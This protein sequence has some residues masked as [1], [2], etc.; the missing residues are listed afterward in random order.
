M[1]A[2]PHLKIAILDDY[3]NV[4][5]TMADW[6]PLDGRA[7]ITVFNDTLSDAADIIRRL[8]PFDIVCVMRERTP[9]TR[10]IIEALPDLKLVTSTGPGN[11]S[12]DT[13][14]ATEKGIDVRHTAYSSV[15]TVELTWGLILALA[16]NIPQE[17]RSLQDG[18]WQ[19]SVGDELAERSE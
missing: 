4:A 13:D 17:I 2:A 7:D 15:P 10:Q 18:G 5:L 6:S 19:R 9:L 14:A 12:I 1:P 3:Q 11:Q 16:R 8:K